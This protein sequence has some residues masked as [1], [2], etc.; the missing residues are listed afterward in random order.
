V[1]V[2]ATFVLWYRSQGTRDVHTVTRGLHAIFYRS[3]V[4]ATFALG[5]AVGDLSAFTFGLGYRSPRSRTPP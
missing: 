1:L 3:A 5:T 4:L 2:A